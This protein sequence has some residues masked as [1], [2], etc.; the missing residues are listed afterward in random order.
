MSEEV[1]GDVKKKHCNIFNFPP[2]Q[3]EIYYP[4]KIGA[5]GQALI[6]PQVRI[7]T[8]NQRRRLSSDLTVMSEYDLP[9]DKT[10]EFTRE[11]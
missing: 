5:E 10:W 6:V 8:T 7:E 4:N 11:R 3:N 1:G 2:P 9:L